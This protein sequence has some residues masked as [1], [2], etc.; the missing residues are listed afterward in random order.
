MKVLEIE[1]LRKVFPASRG[2]AIRALE[3]I[4]LSIEEG[5]TF[6]L[7]GGSGSGKTTLALCILRV[8]E[9]SG[10]NIRFMGQDWLA[11]KGDDL[12]SRRKRMQAIFQDPDSSL[13]PRFRVWQVIEEPLAVHQMGNS[14]E[15]RSRVEALAL[16]VGLQPA[17]LERVPKELSGGQRQRVAIARALATEPALLI[18]DEPF[19]SLD[20]ATQLR[21]MQLLSRL[22]YE[23]RLT[24]LFISHDLALVGSFCDVVAVIWRGRL[25]ETGK[26]S[27]LFSEPLHPYTEA[28]LK[29][30][31][32]ERVDLE[33][34]SSGQKN[35]QLLEARPGHF[36]A[37]R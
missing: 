13:N 37:E 8:L 21:T 17:D 26:T 20:A 35:G 29:A 16:K 2:P 19:S 12:Q 4:S 36:V 24:T 15:R 7:V 18:A 33:K 32:G 11:P 27:D 5:E 34:V 14:R 3:T 6:G 31:E 28:L 23:L 30:A 10:G 9:P 22:K 25:V 1:N